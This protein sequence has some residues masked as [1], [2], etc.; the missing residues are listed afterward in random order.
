MERSRGSNCVTV[1]NFVEITPTAAE[2]WWFFDF[3]HGGRRHLGFSKFEFFNGQNGQD[4]RTASLCQISSKS[5]ELRPNYGDFLIFQ[6]CAVLALILRYFT[7]F[8]SFWHALRKIGWQS[9]N[10]GQFTIVM[11]SSKRLQRDRHLGFSKFS[12]FNGR[13]ASACQISSKKPELRPR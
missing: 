4:G 8:G 1:P 10:Y 12:I 5:F 3:Q 11:S 6:D 13:S 2:I 7:E 9:H